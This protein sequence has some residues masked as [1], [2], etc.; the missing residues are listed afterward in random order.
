MKQYE[1][2]VFSQVIIKLIFVLFIYFFV[3]HVS[4]CN[5]CMV[6]VNP[7]TISICQSG[8]CKRL[9]SPD[10]CP[11]HPEEFYMFG[12]VCKKCVKN[13]YVESISCKFCYKSEKEYNKKNY[14]D[15]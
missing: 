8:E 11:H 15:N 1:H 13:A 5:K 2:F 7:N 6:A 4:V 9:K 14:T 12:A 3:V 10:V